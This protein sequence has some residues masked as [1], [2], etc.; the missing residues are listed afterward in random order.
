[1]RVQGEEMRK[2]LSR[3]LQS[4]FYWVNSTEQFEGKSELLISKETQSQNFEIQQ[5]STGLVS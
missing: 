4:L 1:M 3:K 2:L 5:W